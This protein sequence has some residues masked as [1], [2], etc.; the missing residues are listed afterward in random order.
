VSRYITEMNDPK[1]FHDHLDECE[2]CEKNPFDLCPAG[3]LILK[4]VTVG[5][6]L[7]DYQRYFSRIVQGVNKD[8]SANDITKMVDEMVIGKGEIMDLLNKLMKESEDA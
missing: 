4:K 6:D 7:E 5:I 3:E 2:K 1:D 8:N